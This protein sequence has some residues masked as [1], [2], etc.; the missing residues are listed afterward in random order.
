MVIALENSSLK[1]HIGLMDQ[2]NSLGIDNLVVAGEKATLIHLQGD[3]RREDAQKIKDILPGS[4]RL[5]D[6]KK[7]YPLVSRESLPQGSIIDV[8]GVAIGGKAIQIISGPCSVETPEQMAKAADMVKRAG[9]RLMRGGAFKPRTNPYSFQGHGVDG[10][11][12]LEQAARASALPMVTELLDVRH[13]EHFLAAG[14]DLIQIGTRNMQNFELLKEVGRT[15]TP[16]LLKRGMCATIKEWLNAAEY[17]AASGNLNI[18][19]CERGVRSFENAYRNML[20]VTAIPM[21]KRETHLP[22]M[23]DPSHAAGCASLVPV[24]SKAAIAAGADGLIIES[25]HQPEQAWCDAE[26]AL[27]P[28]EL[29]QLMQELTLIA[30]SVKRDI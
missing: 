11:V 21:L 20:D 19:L 14:V 10:L 17:I 16:V 3:N 2:L 24:L 12:M 29:T 25:H 23:I 9:C 15:K 7:T 6:T 26:Q 4:I 8:A 1:N 30:N 13:L 5:I 22:V 18:I 27:N 28:E